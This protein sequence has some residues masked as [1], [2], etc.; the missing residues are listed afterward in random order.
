[1]EADLR[2]L[3]SLELVI[4]KAFL[5]GHEYVSTITGGLERKSRSGLTE[6]VQELKTYTAILSNEVLDIIL[7][8]LMAKGA[9]SSA[10]AKHE[11][12]LFRVSEAASQLCQTIA[13]ESDTG[14]I[15]A[16]GEDL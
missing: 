6:L 8:K 14:L 16:I 15:P 9:A 7:E 4:K 13:Q 2:R 11:T 12:P 3:K 10:K 5:A 1:M